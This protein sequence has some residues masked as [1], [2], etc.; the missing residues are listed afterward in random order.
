MVDFIDESENRNAP[1]RA[2]FEQFLCLRFHA[3]GNVND[4]DG[5]VDRHECSVRI[6][7][8]I[9]VARRIQNI[10]TAPVVIKLEHRT[11]DGNAALF[12]Y[13]HPVGNSIA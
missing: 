9:G 2:N 13:F 1:V 11:C 7:R 5:T 4:H 8:E 3:F 10:D 12:F 6:F